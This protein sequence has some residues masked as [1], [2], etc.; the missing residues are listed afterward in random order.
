VSAGSWEVIYNN[1]PRF[2][3]AAA[4]ETMPV[5]RKGEGAAERMRA[6]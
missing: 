5:A 2:G 3:L 4:G 6:H 1:M